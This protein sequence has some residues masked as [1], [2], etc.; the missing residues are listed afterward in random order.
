[1]VS[2][3]FECE[4]VQLRVSPF[5]ITKLMTGSSDDT[6]WSQTILPVF[7]KIRSILTQ[8]KVFLFPSASPWLWLLIFVDRPWPSIC[9]YQPWRPICIYRLWSVR[10]LSVH[11]P[12]LS[13]QPCIYWSWPT[14]CI[15]EL[16]ICICLFIGSISRGSGKLAVVVISLDQI[17]P[18]LVC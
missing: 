9:I 18:I 11:I 13:P 12:T 1:M 5:L 2:M 6:M 16:W 17:I 14:I 3:Y 7:S 8:N 15:T 10:T 4:S